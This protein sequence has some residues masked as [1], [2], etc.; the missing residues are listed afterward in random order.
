MS[1]T[2]AGFTP[3]IARRLRESG[4]RIVITGAGGWLGR[5]TLELIADALGAGW[6][7]RV[8]C[9]GSSARSLILTD[10]LTIDQRPL[11]EMA[12]L[13]PR[14][15]LTLHLAFLTKDRAEAMDEASY[16]RANEALTATVLEALSPIGTDAVFV[17]SSGAANFADDPGSSHAMRLY[18][19]MKRTDEQVFANWA[20][21]DGKRA[22]ICRIFNIAGRHINK[23]QSYALGSFIDDALAGRPV[24][25]KAPH[26]VV[27]GNVAIRELMSLVF[28]MMLEEGAAPVT[29]FESGGTPM[30]L[31]EIAEIVAETLG[32][33]VVPRAAPSAESANIYVG[34]DAA[35]RQLLAQY[36]IDEVPFETQVVETA[37]YLRNISRA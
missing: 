25:V 21:D 17:A 6:K 26:A 16:R 24:T 11:V 14:P 28:A 8:R 1:E 31:G 3:A 33:P 19:E 23:V 4:H 18:G 2:L 37:N 5:A 15:T 30:E 20:V 36:S 10:D 13:D 29:Q 34:N 27:R 35:Y 9:F 22:V 7:D 32:A 12:S